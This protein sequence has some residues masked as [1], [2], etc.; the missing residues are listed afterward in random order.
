MAITQAYTD[1]VRVPV[2]RR[3]P[4][5]VSGLAAVVL[6]LAYF[7]WAGYSAHRVGG[8]DFVKGVFDAS[9][10]YGRAFEY[11]DTYHLAEGIAFAVAGGLALAG[12]RAAKGALIAMSGLVLYDAA[13]QLIG[14]HRHEYR[15]LYT[16][17]TQ[18]KL[19]I[20]TMVGTAVLGVLIIVVL[21]A[22]GSSVPGNGPAAYAPQQP[23]WPQQAP[24]YPPQQGY[25]PP[26]PPAQG[27]GQPPSGGYGYPAPPNRP[28][29][30]GY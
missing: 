29:G 19:N 3:G 2:G 23:P 5:V 20:A 9:R 1:P 14:L 26:Q 27:Y 10:V 7:C 17:T 4:Y 15:E 24:N 11:V 30:S 18:G 6:A 28:P 25:G 12:R 8:G 16:H 13:Q 22:A 21:L